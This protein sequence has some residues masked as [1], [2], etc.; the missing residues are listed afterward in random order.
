MAY[1]LLVAVGRL[2][3]EVAV[4]LGTHHR[5]EHLHGVG[6]DEYAR[7][8]THGMHAVSAQCGRGDRVGVLRVQAGEAL[9]RRC[10]ARTS[11]ALLVPL[12]TMATLTDYTHCGYTY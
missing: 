10:R 1:Q 4:G 6:R 9:L 11:H 2:E 5:G 12:L 8:T 7:R 3:G